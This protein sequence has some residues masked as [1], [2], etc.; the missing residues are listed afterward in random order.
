KALGE[1]FRSFAPSLYCDRAI[2]GSWDRGADE[3]IKP[4]TTAE[5]MNCGWGWQI[6][7]EHHINRG[8][9]HSSAYLSETDAEAELRA[10]NPKMG[11]TR[12]VRYVSGRYERNWVK[13]VVAIGNAS[14]FVEPLESTGLAVIGQM[15]LALA[16]A[17]EDGDRTPGPA[18]A[19]Q[20]NKRFAQH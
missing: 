13:N 19:G 16:V 15:S 14:G 11:P 8:Y 6:D 7:H 17:L 4:Y 10:K 20:F 5:T 9:V 1:P 3:P 2:V 18:I 12:V